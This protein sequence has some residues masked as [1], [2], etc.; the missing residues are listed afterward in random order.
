MSESNT[1]YIPSEII[2][3][4]TSN[5]QYMPKRVSKAWKEAIEKYNPI[6]VGT[7]KAKYGSL[8]QIY[9]YGTLEEIEYANR[10]NVVSV[11]PIRLP[12]DHAIY[13]TVDIHKVYGYNIHGIAQHAGWIDSIPVDIKVDII[14]SLGNYLQRGD[15]VNLAGK[16]NPD[17]I[18]IFDGVS[19]LDFPSDL[20]RG[21]IPYEFWVGDE[22]YA[23]HWY[24]MYDEQGNHV[25]IANSVWINHDIHRDQLL[26]NLTSD[27]TYFDGAL[28][29]FYIKI[30]TNDMKAAI[31]RLRSILTT[32]TPLVLDVEDYYMYHEGDPYTLWFNYHISEEY[33]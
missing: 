21:N 17:W 22:F 1:V 10:P 28:G 9:R 27:G 15:I 14:A 33:Y 11:I 7:L 3:M 16:Y 6:S 25:Y 30:D 32:G 18:T 31:H 24:N 26:A 13:H 20:E 12:T 5:L 8:D 23:D 2:G 29:R 19:L 4:I